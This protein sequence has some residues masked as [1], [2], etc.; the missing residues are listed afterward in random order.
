MK[1]LC[2]LFLFLVLLTAIGFDIDARGGHGG[3]GH[4]GGRGRRG[5][6]GRRHGRGLRGGYGYGRRGYG[7]GSGW[8]WGTGLGV[9]LGTTALVAGTAAAN[10]ENSPV[11]VTQSTIEDESPDIYVDQPEYLS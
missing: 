5:H 10:A 9:G 4:H 8:G 2:G 7:Y 3:H 6:H 11:Y 1:K